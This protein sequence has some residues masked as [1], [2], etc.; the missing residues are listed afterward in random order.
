MSGKR[1]VYIVPG[2]LGR[3]P[4]HPSSTL[5][6]LPGDMTRTLA[7][8]GARDL[9]T[10]QCVGQK[11]A[12]NAPRR[13]LHSSSCSAR[14]SRQHSWV[15]RFPCTRRAY[16]VSHAYVF[17][18]E[19]D[20]NP[21]LGRRSVLGNRS[22]L[23][24][25]SGVQD[26]PNFANGE[27]VYFISVADGHAGEAAAEFANTMLHEIFNVVTAKDARPIL[28]AYHALCNG[29]E[30]SGDALKAVEADA[31]AFKD[32]LTLKQRLRLAFL[33][34]DLDFAAQHPVGAARC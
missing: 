13:A 15:P 34:T 27:P 25:R 11:T 28:G 3:C 7:S 5:L 20:G 31:S 22:T 2:A 16:S 24:D 19:T 21:F 26:S 30:P 6:P 9:E 1:A 14:D 23:E 18:I 29:T 8:R 32:P 17:D 12:W 10:A 4:V 33:K